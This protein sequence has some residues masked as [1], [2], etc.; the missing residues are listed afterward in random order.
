[1]FVLPA[2]LVV[3]LMVVAQGTNAGENVG[4]GDEVNESKQVAVTKHKSEGFERTLKTLKADAGVLVINDAPKLEWIS[5]LPNSVTW[6]S[7][8]KVTTLQSLPQ[9]LPSSLQS[10]R[11][12]FRRFRFFRSPDDPRNT[13]YL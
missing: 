3:A 13:H 4:D 8:Q 10:L 6:L 11:L 2:F 7:L 1:M 5:P 9:P 12:Y